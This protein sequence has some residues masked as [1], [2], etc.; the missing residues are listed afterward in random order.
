MRRVIVSVA[1]TPRY[2]RGLERLIMSLQSNAAGAVMKIRHELPL[3]WP[4]HREI[5]FGFKAYAL[6]RANDADMLMWCDSCIV[7]VRYWGPLWEKIERDGYFFMNNGWSNYEWTADSAYQDL[8]R[9]EF[10]QG[11]TLEDVRRRNRQIKHVVGGFFGLNLNHKIGKSILN[12]FYQ[13]AAYTKAFCGPLQNTPETPCG[14][15]D[16]RGHR[17]DQTALSVLAWRYGCQL[18]DAPEFF[19]Y[20]KPEEAKDPRTVAVADGSYS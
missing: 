3:G 2:F 10:E 16:V 5:P 8:F 12:D 14:P 6:D 19:I 7:A 18:T 4:N 1:T 15:P 17:H 13:L 20:G 9:P 11:E